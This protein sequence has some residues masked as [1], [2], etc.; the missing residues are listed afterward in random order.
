MNAQ[1]PYDNEQDSGGLSPAKMLTAFITIFSLVIIAGLAVYYS[2]GQKDMKAKIA[3]QEKAVAAAQKA[4]D[5]EDGFLHQPEEA[6][7]VFGFKVPPEYHL[8][9][10]PQILADGSGSVYLVHDNANVMFLVGKKVSGVLP[11]DIRSAINVYA[12]E[13]LSEKADE[14]LA[15][16][17]ESKPGI[18]YLGP[19]DLRLSDGTPYRLLA[20]IEEEQGTRVA[21]VYTEF[22]LPNNAML[23]VM[24]YRK[25]IPEEGGDAEVMAVAD[26]LQEFLIQTGADSEAILELPEEKAVQLPDIPLEA[27]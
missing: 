27:Q 8:A 4:S 19:D 10:K 16:F 5:N 25:G 6:F 24:A 11:V 14:E 22:V 18:I 3:E 26:A 15:T 21:K 2:M 13:T 7:D 20:Y 9:Q 12:A 1:E 17:Y 23:S